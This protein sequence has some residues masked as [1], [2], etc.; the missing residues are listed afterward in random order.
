MHSKPAISKLSLTIDSVTDSNALINTQISDGYF[1]PIINFLEHGE[2]TGHDK[3][4]RR[5]VIESEWFHLDNGIL[6]RNDNAANLTTLAV[7]EIC[8]LLSIKT[9]KSY[10]YHHASNG[11]IECTM[12]MISD[13]FRKFGQDARDWCHLLKVIAF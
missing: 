9:Q 6:Y 8:H 10:A 11:V 5:I 7:K 13:A 12:S 2:L 4:D 1:A 3:L